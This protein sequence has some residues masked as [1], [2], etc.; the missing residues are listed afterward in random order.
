MSRSSLGIALSGAGKHISD[1]FGGKDQPKLKFNFGVRFV[2]SDMITGLD[3]G[4]DDMGS[5]VF[6]IKQI[7]R[8]APNILY[9]DV[10]YYNYMTKVATKIDFAIVTIQMYD[11]VNNKIHKIFTKYLESIS[12]I[13]S[14]THESQ[15]HL[16]HNQGRGD[17]SNMGPHTDQGINSPIN[18]IRVIQFL[19]EC[20]KVYYDYVNPKIQTVALDELDMSQSDVNTI[21]F[22]FMYDS[23]HVTEVNETCSGDTPVAAKDE[24]ESEPLSFWETALRAAGEAAV[25]VRTG[26]PG[27]GTTNTMLLG[28]QL[29][30]T[31][32]GG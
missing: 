28:S 19:P 32:P 29:H 21:T 18:M 13:A 4:Q 10:N 6:P 5:N 20:R 9:E 22:N 1:D 7:T 17:A 15:Y 25:I 24:P 12:P 26:A 11:D 14:K 2:Y 27:I 23:V 31:K 3:G 16:L 30:N 8:P